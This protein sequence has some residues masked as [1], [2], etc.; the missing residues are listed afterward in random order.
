MR[1]MVLAAMAL[2][3]AGAAS[4]AWACMP[5]PAKGKDTTAVT[6]P[7]PSIDTE[8]PAVKKPGA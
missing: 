8:K 2:A 4:S 6:P 3:I 7:V 5:P 1:F